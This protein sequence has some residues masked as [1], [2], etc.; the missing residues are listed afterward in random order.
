VVL[1]SVGRHPLASLW[2]GLQLNLLLYW[3]LGAPPG[4]LG[5]FAHELGTAG[6]MSV[7]NT[8]GIWLVAPLL[9]LLDTAARAAAPLARPRDASDTAFVLTWALSGLITYLFWRTLTR[10]GRAWLQRERDDG[11]VVPR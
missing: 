10:I 3:R 7:L 8:P 11:S 4:P 6:A 2:C 9:P 1:E 5:R